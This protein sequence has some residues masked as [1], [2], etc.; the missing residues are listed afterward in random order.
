MGNLAASLAFAQ[1]QE[2]HDMVWAG[3]SD[4]AAAITLL[5]FAKDNPRSVFVG[6]RNAENLIA[7]HA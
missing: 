4:I 2:E 7:A 6:E 1:K 5:Q 3:A